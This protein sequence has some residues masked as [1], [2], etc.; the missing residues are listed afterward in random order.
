MQ[1]NKALRAFS[2]ISLFA[3]T[4]S[5]AQVNPSSVTPI[6]EVQE[7]DPI[8]SMLDSLVTLN[9]VIRYN[10]LDA[11]TYDNSA[12]STDIPVFSDE[13]MAQRISQINSPIPLSYNRYVKE[14]ISLYAEKK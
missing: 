7:Y 5:S 11:N 2:L 9:N 4:I 13:V 12:A 1:M 14:F 10:S 6:T 3:V 8:V